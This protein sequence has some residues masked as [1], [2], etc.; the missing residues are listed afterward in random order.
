MGLWHFES[1]PGCEAAPGP[2]PCIPGTEDCG[3][4]C[5]PTGQCGAGTC[6]RDAQIGCAIGE[7]S[8]AGQCCDKRATCV[9]DVCLL[10]GH[11]VSSSSCPPTHP[12]ACGELCCAPEGLCREDV[13]W[14]CPDG[15]PVPC[16][17]LCCLPDAPCEGLV[18]ACPEARVLCGDL[19]C[20]AG[21]L[22][23]AGACTEPPSGGGGC[24][25][26]YDFNLKDPQFCTDS[27]CSGCAVLT[28]DELII[29]GTAFPASIAGDGTLTFT[30]PCP[31]GNP[32]SGT[33]TG[34]LVGTCEWKGTWLCTDGSNSGTACGW[35]M[36]NQH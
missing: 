5:C 25:G 20:A 33:F 13:C 35:S 11:P 22:C 18:C 2:S 28:G 15:H 34:T 36:G 23:S 19:C 30:T 12:T 29:D 24:A 26:T 16:G 31:N 17:D 27:P 14:E 1:I 7:V 10:S 8:C 4:G 9:D 32:G 3:A 21:Q 6:V